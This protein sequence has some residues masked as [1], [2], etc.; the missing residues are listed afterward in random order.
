MSNENF[1]KAL[2]IIEKNISECD[3]IGRRPKELIEK[4]ENVLGL[5]FSNQYKKFLSTYGA[6]CIGSQE[7][8]GIIRDDFENSSVPDVVWVNRQNRI[9]FG[10]PDHLLEIYHTGSDEVFCF[11]FKK[12]NKQGEPPVVVYVPGLDLKYQTYERIAEDFGDFLLYLLDLE[13]LL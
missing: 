10:M 3:F 5:N 2:S 9:K 11:D 4:A 1:E 6:L 8:Y 12:T 13:E 7:V